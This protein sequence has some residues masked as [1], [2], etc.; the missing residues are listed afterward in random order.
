MQDA[1]AREPG[2]VIRDCKACPEIVVV[3]P[4]SFRMG[5]DG[6]EPVRSSEDIRRYEGPE[7][8]V[9]IT[10]A[11]GVGR[12]EV[13]NEQFA[14]FVKDT[15]YVALAG[16]FYWDGWNAEWVKTRGWE[17][18]GYGR[19]PGPKE[20]VVCVSWHAAR[21]YVDW[22][23]SKTGASYRLL[24]EA[25]W[26]YAARAGTTAAHQ[27]G[28]QPERA[29]EYANVFDASAVKRSP[30]PR[31]TAAP[32]DDGYPQVAPV[33]SFKPNAFGLYDMAGNVWEWIQDCHVM[34][35]PADAPTDGSAVISK[36]C[37]RRGNKGGA[38]MTTVDRQ[39]FTFRGRDPA[40]QNSLAFGFRVARDL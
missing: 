28:E 7:R 37:D 3:P 2:D 13:T 14:A 8:T 35:Y 4:G 16:C 23:S 20:P 19:P 27:W 40:H 36:V 9:T 12:F 17:D 30:N 10:R 26:E 22:L 33:G 18:P 29:C 11:F 5:W 31:L 6:A 24:T 34:P 39:R 1:P 15:G 25:E 38:W 21:A 32:C